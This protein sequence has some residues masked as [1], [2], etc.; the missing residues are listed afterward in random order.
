MRIP[1]V[2]DAWLD[3]SLKQKKVLPFKNYIIPGFVV[4]VESKFGVKKGAQSSLD[5][6][7]FIPLIKF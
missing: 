6:V 4:D 5:P 1:I 7:C 3:E 2:D